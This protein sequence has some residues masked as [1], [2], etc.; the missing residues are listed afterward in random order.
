VISAG[1][2][3]E[4][5]NRTYCHPRASTVKALTTALGGPG[6]STVKAFD[7]K[8]ACKEATDAHWID[9]PASDSLWA[10]ER[11]GDVVLRAWRLWQCIERSPRRRVARHAAPADLRTE[12]AGVGTSFDA[13]A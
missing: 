6:A 10:T 5:T 11:D 4:G 9:V 3:N 7:A 1:K 8:V 2:P 12:R 13:R